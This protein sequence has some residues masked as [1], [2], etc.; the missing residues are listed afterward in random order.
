MYWCINKHVLYSPVTGSQSGCAAQLTVH[1]LIACLAHTCIFMQVFEEINN[2][3]RI[4][5]QCNMLPCLLLKFSHQA[6]NV[7]LLWYPTFWFWFLRACMIF[8]IILYDGQR[9]QFSNIVIVLGDALILFSCQRR[10]RTRGRFSSFIS[11]VDIISWTICRR[12]GIF[13]NLF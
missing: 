13:S 3:S 7:E 8:R 5:E 10:R 4:D 1:Y 11:L 9:F 2:A 6:Y 12:Y